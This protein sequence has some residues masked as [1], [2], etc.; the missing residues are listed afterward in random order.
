MP[1][2]QQAGGSLTT[3]AVLTLLAWGVRMLRKDGKASLL[4]GVHEGQPLQGRFFSTLSAA[5]LRMLV[6]F[7][8]FGSQPNQLSVTD[9]VFNVFLYSQN[10]MLIF[11]AWTLTAHKTTSNFTEHSFMHDLT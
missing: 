7:Q 5:A 4:P 2:V 11:L 10:V 1:L 3:A 6:V 8:F 9:G